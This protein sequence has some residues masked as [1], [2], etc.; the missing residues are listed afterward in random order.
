MKLPVLLAILLTTAPAFADL[1][2][3]SF[4][5]PTSG[6]ALR[7][8]ADCEL[9]NV[10]AP[11]LVAEF[12]DDGRHWVV[13]VNRITLPHATPLD[14]Y[15]DKDGQEQDGL[16]D[17]TVSDL[18]QQGDDVVTQDLVHVGPQGK[19]PVGIVVYRD[20][21]GGQRRL[22]QKALVAGGDRLYYTVE[23]DCPSGS[24]ADAA[25]GDPA[26]RLEADSFNAMI[27]SVQLLDR[28]A[29]YQD[30][31]DRLI[32][33]RGLLANWTADYLS[34]RMEP[35]L[36]FRLL[37][38]GQDVGFIIES[39]SFEPGDPL[40]G[41][42]GTVKI[43]LR[44]R[45][46][47]PGGATVDSQSRFSVS[48]D[49]K[50]ESWVSAAT[51]S[52]PSAQN[53]AKPLV[54]QVDETGVSDDSLA[55]VPVVAPGQGLEPGADAAA[56]QNEIQPG[57]TL[58]DKWV[59]TV[60]RRQGSIVPP[61]FKQ[62]VPPWYLPQ[63]LS[64]ILPRLL[65]QR[66]AKTYLF[67]AYEPGADGGQA[68]VMMRY[69]DVLSPADVTLDGKDVFAVP[70]KDRIGLEGATTTHYL[71]PED[72]SYLGSV[73]TIPGR[74]ASDQA[75]TQMI[76]PTDADA[77]KQLWPNCDLSAPVMTPNPAGSK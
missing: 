52:T 69:V 33:T 73:I 64:S 70:V 42:T 61:T 46:E 65:P 49:R 6:I 40:K 62:E 30:Q 34:Q 74:D 77:L 27:D 20:L 51:V 17:Q 45:T 26:E 63:A 41:G 15:K 39:D 48:T 53:G 22:V 11:D 38:N 32:R 76:L 5:S 9:V 29:I 68:A 28:S 31:S 13:K 3:D 12:V 67:A 37:R 23:L 59:V 75:T 44:S 8:P 18:R 71:S 57:I 10:M 43:G 72:G 24:A 1:L 2:G 54:Q 50:H 58:R 16:L 60:V 47:L 35:I 19:L 25:S 14:Q 55:A 7:P 56:E 21:A 4:S 66:E 36:Y